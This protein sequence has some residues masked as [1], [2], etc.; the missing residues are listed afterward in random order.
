MPF[1]NVRPRNPLVTNPD[2]TPMSPAPP[3]AARVVAL[4]A[5]RGFALLGIFAVN[6]QS[7]A[8]PSGF[9]SAIAPWSDESPLSVA[10]FYLVRVFCEGKFYPLFSMLFGMGLVLQMARVGTGF[11]R[12]YARRLGT[13]I[14]FGFL[15]ATL[16]WS[17]DILFVYAIAGFV[18][19][20]ASRLSGRA[21]LAVG[22]IGLVFVSLLGG[23][24]WGAAA[25]MGESAI[26][27]GV[28]Q[29]MA[30]ESADET[31]AILPDEPDETTPIHAPRGQAF[32]T[33][34]RGVRDGTLAFSPNDSAWISLETQAFREGPWH[35][36]FLFNLV[37]W[38]F[39]LI[40]GAFGYGWHVLALFFLG[41]GLMRLGVF[42][43]DGAAWRTRLLI[44]GLVVGLPGS[45]AAVALPV[46]V[47][48]WTGYTVGTALSFLCG[49]MLS[50]LY[51]CTIWRLA[52][53]APLRL[54]VQTIERVGRMALTNYLLHTLLFT[55]IFHWWGL[56]LF[57]E[58][59]RPQRLAVVPLVYL[60]LCITSTLWLSRFTMGP[61][62]WLW[63]TIT[64]WK[65][66][67]LRRSRA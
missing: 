3:S 9:Y 65:A 49:P 38:L 53:L 42:G 4:D 33:L 28:T 13:L 59:S 31:S 46:W 23:A 12:I 21:L 35:D 5:A 41:A 57:A 54:V 55:A 24:C 17:G 64:Y 37:T 32:A 25:H 18:L 15:H 34:A 58:L 52:Y 56:G 7:F 47:G 16:M 51:L 8:E 63:R 66:Q 45:I 22:V 43:P 36:A 60:V 27:S 14:V 19:L 2:P 62:E 20:L 29:A 1:S 39:S 48:G 50:L 40:A 30:N 6:V 10:L 44:V 67:P 61:M 11:T 26:E